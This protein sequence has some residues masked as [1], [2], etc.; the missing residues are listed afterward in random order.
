MCLKYHNT[1]DHTRIPA[2]LIQQNSYRKTERRHKGK[3]IKAR[4]NTLARSARSKS[5]EGQTS[6]LAIE[7]LTFNQEH[8]NYL[9][10]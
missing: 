5:F 9:L 3:L 10:Q 6:E 2:T 8:H 4:Q 7:A 1:D